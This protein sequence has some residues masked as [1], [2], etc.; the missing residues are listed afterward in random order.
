M[1]WAYRQTGRWLVSLVG[2]P[3]ALTSGQTVGVS[4]CFA[5]IALHARPFLESVLASF[6]RRRARPGIIP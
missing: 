4:R 3:I 5:W 6:G 1:R 2:R